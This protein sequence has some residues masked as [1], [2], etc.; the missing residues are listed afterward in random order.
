[1]ISILHN[2]S[3][4][5]SITS[6]SF[7][8][9]FDIAGIK[10]SFCLAI[11]DIDGDGRADLLVTSL[12]A[13]I[14]AS[15]W[16]NISTVGSLSAN[17]FAPRVDISSPNFRGTLLA[18]GD[19]D[20]DGKPDLALT[21][22][23]LTPFSVDYK[24]DSVFV[25]RNT[26]TIGTFNHA[27]YSFAAPVSF[28]T[29][30]APRYVAI[31]DLDGDGKPDLAAPNA[32][33]NTVSVLRNTS[34][35]GS[36]IA[37]S[38]A[39]HVDFATN[40][41]PIRI[42]IS[43]LDGDSK[44]DLTVLNTEDFL[45]NDPSPN[46]NAASVLRNTS[47]SGSITTGSFAPRV[48]FDL[49]NFSFDPA[50]GD[51]DGDGKP[52]LAAY[53]STSLTPG[54][55]SVIRNN[56]IFAP[57]TQAANV[58]FSGTAASFTTARWTNGNGSARAVF[59]AEASTGSP[60]PVNNVTYTANPAFGS[61][62]QI[63]SSGWYCTYN[64]TDDTVKITGLKLGSTYRV[65][66]LEYYGVASYE[67]YLTSTAT[68][69]PANITTRPG[70][71][72]VL[73]NLTISSGSLAPGFAST[74]T[75][76]IRIVGGS[77][78]TLTVTPTPIDPNAT[79]TVNG[80]SP[81]VPVNL[82]VGTNNITVKVTSQDGTSTTTYTIGITAPN[83]T[84]GMAVVPVKAGMPV[85]LHLTNTGGPV[86]TALYGQVTTVAGSTVDA[87]GYVNSEDTSALFNWPQAMIKDASGNLYITDSN[88]NAIRMISPS[89]AVTTFAGSTTGQSGNTDGT[90]TSALFSY[91][92]GI[93][94][95]KAGNLFV[96]DYNNNAIR[97]ITSGGVVTTFYSTTGTFGP[98]G[99]CFDTSGDLIVTAQD[100]SQVVKITPAGLATTIAGNTPGYVNGTGTAAL[101]N[102]SSDV[103]ADTLGN[104]YVA[105]FLNNAIRKINPAGVVTT[106][107][108]SDVTGNMAGYADGVGTAAVFN[109]PTGLAIGPGRVIYVADIYN[110]DI[111]K[112]MPDG[113]VTLVAG[114][115]AQAPGY[116]DGTGTAARFN[117]PANMYIDDN[118]IGYI[119]E[120]GGNRVRKIMLTG[121]TINGTLPPGLTFDVN[122]GTISGTIT[123]PF[124]SQTDTVSAYNG[125]GHSSTIITFSSSIATLSNLVP[126]SGTFTPVF[127]SSTTNYTIN[128]PNSA[129]SI[130]L[131]P[132]A[133]DSTA[134]IK[135]NR[136][137]VTSGTVSASIPLTVGPNTI[138]T[139]VTA[140]DGI[141]TDTYTV[142]VTRA[143]G[144]D[145]TLAD[146]SA[147]LGVLAPAFSS[148]ITAYAD[149]VANTV[150][151]ITV[152]PTT[153]DNNATVIVN[154]ATITSGTASA[155]I[156][157][158]IGENTITIV[159]TAQDGVTTDTYTL[160]VYRGGP[161]AAIN[162]TNILTP[163]GDGKNDYWT[164]QDIQLYPQNI[165]SVY[166]R[167]GRL[168]YS[169]SGYN[170]DWNGTSNGSLL[171]QGIYY[172]IVHLGPNLRKFRGSINIMRN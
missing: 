19:L 171:P 13:G 128:V 159:V 83:I 57:S 46:H 103:K 97:K 166:D 157:L 80:G 45:F 42:A 14:A 44:P 70:S 104:L 111:R 41:D 54:V 124:A 162:A 31:G 136:V 168:V 112:I 130:T 161:M 37:G 109:N 145:A 77:T 96:A 69:N 149:S 102:E 2:T 63:G 6:S 89:G 153:H 51:L 3:T 105:D 151:S 26:S 142:T 125:V 140:Q 123:A 76:Y 88:N 154:G 86:E 8:P 115:T 108:G 106:F 133:T 48:D 164:I 101:F 66:V 84:Y 126:S 73:S 9:K 34:T 35:I 52:D 107:A 67:N 138:T 87:S 127:A 58:T 90:G 71:N 98:G 1:M 15:V 12:T 147:N 100:A 141:T 129:A 18:V 118:G 64:G 114:S 39:P 29:G 28:A 110:N 10:N 99:I 158:T 82:V 38:F 169:K 4:I 81:S 139:E 116:A 24:R 150:T 79:V 47:F 75:S 95:D 62:T 137:A 131:T 156:P 49:G 40:R 122:T 78:A 59:I 16:Q 163:N 27:N 36:I 172:Y 43:D 21:D 5:G 85:S 33:D 135:V 17:S 148:A 94:I 30:K 56:P 25:L 32:D 65:M 23:D 22:Y 93:A 120:I 134:T 11:S 50:I 121:Y 132:I 72:S 60:L 117:L 170:N 119:S 91:P 113:T 68:G 61:G 144:S 55:V 146:L 155:A 160:I 165:V 74:I 53:N 20:G 92:D 167:A 143:P 7:A 152:T